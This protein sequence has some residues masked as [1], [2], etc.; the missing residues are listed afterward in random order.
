MDSMNEK[1]VRPSAVAGSFYAGEE[2]ALRRDLTERLEMAEEYRGGCEIVAAAVPHAGYVY[3][4]DIAA[5]VYK[6]LS[7][8]EF[9][10]VVVIGHDFGGNAAGLIGALTR[11]DSFRTPLG[12]VPVDRE[13]CEALTAADRRIICNDSVHRREH[14]V[15]VQLPFLQMV[16]RKPFRIVPMLF[17]E[18]TPEHCRRLAE[19]LRQFQGARRILVLSSTDLSH[20]PSAETARQ[21]DSKTVAFAKS[22]D[23]EGLCRWQSQGEWEGLPHVETPICSAGGLGTAICWAKL[24]GASQA[25]VMRQG[26]SGDVSGD[27]RQVVGYASLLFVKSNEANGELTP[28]MQQGLLKL[29]RRAIADEIHSAKTT[30]DDAIYSDP[31]LLRPAAVFVTLHKHGKLRG[32]IGTTA[33]QLPLRQAI[34]EY[35][36]AAAFDD[37]RFPQV[38]AEE[39]PEL[40]I[41][42]SVL[43]PM[44]PI[45]SPTEIIPGVHGVTVRMGRRSGLF[46]PQ[47]WEQLPDM[48]SFLGYLCAEKAGLPF[49]AWRS[50][51]CELRVFTVHA[52]EESH[53]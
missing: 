37:P 14:S 16:A 18:A 4:A 2:Q 46:L 36:Q 10:T 17:G 48:E 51:E 35:A 28:E 43:S 21:L 41:E 31:A 47:V 6:A 1:R 53:A 7:K 23:V 32:C 38:T 29:A 34:V 49:D 42:I 8:A 24:N 12:E 52:F 20:Y 22:F 9:D 44:R 39:L 30:Y 5:P 19:L 26:N 3:S 27:E 15:E 50:P 33:A 25:V 13:L 45:S 40:H 11:Y